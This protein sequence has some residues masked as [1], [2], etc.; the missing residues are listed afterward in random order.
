[1]KNL[2]KIVI[3]ALCASIPVAAQNYSFTTPIIEHRVNLERLSYA[4]LKAIYVLSVTKWEDG[5][6]IVIFMLP[7]DHP[8]QRRFLWQYLGLTPARYREIINSRIMV[9]KTKPTVVPTETM[10]IQAVGHTPGSIGFV[11]NNVVI[12]AQRGVKPLKIS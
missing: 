11:G 3:A 6:P 8:N 7:Q 4:Q 2:F 10:M 12:N 9:G 5:N 1:M